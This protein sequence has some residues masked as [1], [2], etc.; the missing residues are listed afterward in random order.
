MF[1][2]LKSPKNTVAILLLLVYAIVFSGCQANQNPS[3]DPFSKQDARLLTIATGGTTGPYF[4]IGNGLARSLDRHLV[5]TIASVRSTGGGVENIRLLTEKKAE[6][7]FVMA[8]IASFAYE[9]NQEVKGL[10][11]GEELRAIT[12]LYPNFVHLITLEGQPINSVQ[13]LVGKRV[14]VGDVGSG[15]EVN[16][17]TILKSYGI[18]YDDI[19]EHFLSYKESV[20]EL[21]QGNVDAAFLTSGLPNPAI[22]DLMQ[23]HPVKFIN[24]SRENID[25]IAAHYPYYSYNVIPKGT[26]NN[27]ADISTAAI[28]NLLLTRRDMPEQIVYDMTSILFEELD[29][30]QDAHTAA[31]D[32]NLQ[33]SQDGVSVPFHPGAQKF[34]EEHGINVR[35]LP[36]T[37]H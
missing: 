6:V 29:E 24:I 16:A 10:K 31:R 7:A 3:S 12:S 20:L 19:E 26:Y 1:Y 34:F 18:T 30:L 11:N 13:D 15:T 28:T 36:H 21:K 25:K 27:T 9:G 33:N 35:F 22:Q 32:I 2:L 37:N 23:T 8:D 5:G 14:G 4:A 17:R